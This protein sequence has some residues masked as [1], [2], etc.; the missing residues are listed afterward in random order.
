MPLDRASVAA[1]VRAVFEELRQEEL[2][3]SGQA[4]VVSAEVEI[5]PGGPWYC[6]YE[7]HGEYR[8]GWRIVERHS[9]RAF[10]IPAPDYSEREAL[11]ICVAL[12]GL[13]R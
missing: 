2:L 8:R 4:G 12:N 3:R 10:V 1:A 5:A 7:E 6:E 11:A 13:T 9:A